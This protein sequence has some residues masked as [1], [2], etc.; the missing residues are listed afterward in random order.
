M[1]IIEKLK[2]N[3]TVIEVHNADFIHDPKETMSRICHMLEVT[4]SE[5]YLQMCASNV[6]TE[7]SKSRR[8]VQWW[9]DLINLVADKMKAFEHLRRYSLYS[10]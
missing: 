4:C 10:E 8:L 5:R 2:L 6:F 9:P 1:E 3:V 7:V